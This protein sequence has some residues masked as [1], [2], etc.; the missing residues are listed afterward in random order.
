MSNL[1][2]KTMRFYLKMKKLKSC[3]NK[4]YKFSNVLIILNKNNTKLIFKSLKM[5][6]KKSL[7]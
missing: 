7:I 6:Y 2:F 4:K 3:L 1:Y 5:I